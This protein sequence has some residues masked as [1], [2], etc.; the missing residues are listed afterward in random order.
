MTRP[1]M[2]G[3]D[4]VRD[5]DWKPVTKTFDGWMKYAARMAAKKTKAENYTWHG[6]VIYVPEME[7]CRISMA[8]QK[9]KHRG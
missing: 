5:K 6:V 3:L 8:S 4:Y 2:Y 9:S 1:A 7:Y